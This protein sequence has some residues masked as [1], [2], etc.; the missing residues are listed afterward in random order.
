MGVELAIWTVWVGAVVPT[1]TLPSLSTFTAFV[2]EPSAA[3]R[4]KADFGVRR[5]RGRRHCLA[6][7]E[8]D[9]AAGVGA[10]QACIGADLDLD[11]ALTSGDKVLP[12][13]DRCG[14]LA[15][16]D[17]HIVRADGGS[18]LRPAGLS[19]EEFEAKV[20]RTNGGSTALLEFPW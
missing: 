8:H 11:K 13:V 16:R 6:R 10:V 19:V 1:P 7:R 4:E 14:E 18:D 5:E 15:V 12:K 20:V 2:G 9:E 3:A 17:L